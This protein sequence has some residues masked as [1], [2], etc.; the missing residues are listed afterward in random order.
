MCGE[1]SLNSTNCL[2]LDK[3]KLFSFFASHSFSTA[4]FKTKLVLELLQ[5]KSTLVQI[6][7]KHNILSQNLQN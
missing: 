3:P 7:S 5:N 4:A 2:R 6:A 1:D